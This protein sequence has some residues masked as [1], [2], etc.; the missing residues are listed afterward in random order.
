MGYGRN[1]GLIH[2]RIRCG[3]TQEQAAALAGVSVKTWQAWEQGARFPSG[4]H[5]DIVCH[6]LHCTPGE[7]RT[8]PTPQPD[9][10]GTHYW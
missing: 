6:V 7:L 1:H 2:A 4:R 8:V 5:M 3:Y 10:M 9:L